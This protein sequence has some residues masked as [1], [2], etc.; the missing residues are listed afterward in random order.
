MRSGVRL[1]SPFLFFVLVFHVAGCRT[2]PRQLEPAGYPAESPGVRVAFDYA[3]DSTN[4]A[5]QDGF[6]FSFE[7]QQDFTPFIGGFAGL[8]YQT[9]LGEKVGP[10]GDR[11]R[12]DDLQLVP[13][14][15]G[16]VGR[17]PFWLD[18][19]KWQ[20]EKE[21]VWLPNEPIGFAPYVRLSGG[22]AWLVDIAKVKTGGQKHRVLDYQLLPLLKA[23]LGLEYRLKN[24][25]FWA[26]AGYRYLRIMNTEDGL[27]FKEHNLDGLSLSAGVTFYLW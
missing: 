1:V 10:P 24:L 15:L 21:P 11:H 3:R 12:V 16:L 20:E 14:Y 19:K 13:F 7:Y 23:A 2:W 18:W 8:G 5:W 4:E 17:L 25:G 26:E 9:F 22:A 27:P 6:G